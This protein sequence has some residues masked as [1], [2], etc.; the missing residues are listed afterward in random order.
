MGLGVKFNCKLEESEQAALQ[1]CLQHLEAKA[2]EAFEN[3]DCDCGKAVVQ[4]VDS[5]VQGGAIYDNAPTRP[6]TRWYRNRKDQRGDRQ[7]V[8]QRH[9]AELDRLIREAIGA[10]WETSPT[11]ILVAWPCHTI[12]KLVEC[13][14]PPPVEVACSVVMECTASKGITETRTSTSKSSFGF[15]L[16]AVLELK[17]AAIPLVLRGPH[18]PTCYRI[19]PV[20]SRRNLWAKPSFEPIR[21]RR[22]LPHDLARRSATLP[23]STHR[24]PLARIPTAPYLGRVHRSQLQTQHQDHVL[25]APMPTVARGATCEEPT[26]A[27]P[28]RSDRAL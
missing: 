11:S 24:T 2:N 8:A 26:G 17:Q 22:P 27:S 18:D 13:E 4:P 5:Y 25:L 14:S 3:S 9:C 21:G 6:D 15:K 28:R 23:I 20:N 1:E 10:S 16:K 19:P 12:Y 7:L